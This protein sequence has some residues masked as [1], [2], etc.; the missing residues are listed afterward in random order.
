MQLR[1]VLKDLKKLKKRIKHTQEFEK[2]WLDNFG[3]DRFPIVLKA[4]R[5]Q[6][7]SFYQQVD[8]Y[9]EMEVKE[10]PEIMSKL[11]LR[12]GIEAL[13]RGDAE[14]KQEEIKDK[15]GSKEEK[16]KAIPDDNE[17]EEEEI[18]MEEDDDDDW[19]DEDEEDEESGELDDDWD[20]EYEEEDEEEEESSDEW[21]EL[22]EDDEESEEEV[23]LEKEEKKGKKKLPKLPPKLGKKKETGEDSGKKNKFA[24][25]K[26]KKK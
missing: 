24:F 17:D 5:A 14:E 11:L 2:K 10:D 4:I 25:L 7:K 16:E 15:K 18:L 13:K 21:D 23:V 22:E 9:K 19:D 8:L 6:E 12:G 3:E 26:K 1:E 20:D